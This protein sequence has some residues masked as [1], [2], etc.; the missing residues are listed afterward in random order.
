MIEKSIET[1]TFPYFP[2]IIYI[3]MKKKLYAGTFFLLL[4]LSLSGCSDESTSEVINP[5]EE[6]GKAN[7]VFSAEEWKPGGESGTTSNEQGCYS[8]PS[9]YVEA[10]GMYQAFK[11]GETFFENDFTLATFP[12][13]GL[14]PAWVRSGCMY[15]HPS[16]GHGKRMERY[17]ANDMGNG[18]LLVIYHPTAGKTADDKSYAANSYISEVTGMPQT[19]AMSPF[20]PPID[21]NQITIKW[22]HAIDEHN[23]KFA[24]GET[25]DLI[26]PDVTIPQSAFNTDPKPDNY[27]IR[28][29]STIGIYGS[30]LLDAI[31]D[32]SLRV[33]YAKESPYVALNPNMWDASGNNWAPGAWYTLADGDKRIK[34]F[35]YALTRGSL[36]DGPGANAMWNI[37]NVTR[38]DRHYL[39]TTK[40]WSKAM[41]ED[42]SV[43]QF[44]KENGQ[45]KNSLLHPYYGDGNKD[46]ISTL[47]KKLLGLNTKAD[48]ATYEKYFVK[49][50][51]YGEE[52]SDED[53]YNFMVW[54]RGLG[55]PEARGLNTEEV[56]R[57]KQLFY[58]MGCIA[59]HRPS[60]TTGNDDYWAC[61]IVK[62][63]RKL[64]N[65]PHQKIWPYSDMV[66]HR[67]YMVNDIRT[68]W[69]RTTPLWGRGLSEQETGA[70]D[71]LHDCRARNVIE[72]IMWH[73]YSKESDAYLAS[74]KFYNLSK[75][76]R[77]AVV[78]FINAI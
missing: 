66:Q 72:A 2:Y 55:V 32:D 40:A 23:N 10:N 12:R 5:N 37:T 20:L 48:A 14:G 56:K 15:C 31:P 16:Y 50:N 57:G 77:N 6:T 52:M 63:Q 74:Q 35:T 68:G 73:G 9:P 33:Q 25:Y 21:E 54:H 43:V 3:T 76:D 59:C 47:I 58:S 75:S 49:N 61:A 41:S 39:Y 4:S 30:A 46:S 34:K 42:Q 29:E 28:L 62:G 22:N 78:A 11:K 67:L 27:D 1:H 45:D 17:R 70:Q 38:S 53:Y 19:K 69:C 18:Y 13:K 8:N 44:I 64:P 60:W 26:Y 65:Y 71:R 36:Q 7:D 51:P 24:D